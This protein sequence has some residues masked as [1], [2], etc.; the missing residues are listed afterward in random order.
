[1]TKINC[2]IPFASAEQAQATVDGLKSN[3][4]VNKIFLLAGD[5]AQGTIEGCEMLKVN[6]LTSTATIKAIAEHSD[7]CVT[8]LY[9]KYV[10][11][12]FAPFAIER[13]VK[14]LADTQ[15]GMV[16]ADHYNVT[17]KGADKAPVID[18]QMGS[19]RDDFDFGSVMVFCAECFNKA[20][21]TC[22]R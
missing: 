16:Y 12:K 21:F 3:P 13:F 18:Y 6:N 2:F 20:R 15:S 5:D 9:T 1:M 4:L 7:A 8:L 14:I 17:D 10:T 22:S 11:L 19:L